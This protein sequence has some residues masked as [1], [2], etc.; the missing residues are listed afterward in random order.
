MAPGIFSGY[1]KSREDEP[2]TKLSL[3][4]ASRRSS[5]GPRV[6]RSWAKWLTVA[7]LVL[8][9]FAILYSQVYTNPRTYNLTI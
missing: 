3:G 9:I 2:F 1:L 7:V 4:R 6:R 5:P 8:P